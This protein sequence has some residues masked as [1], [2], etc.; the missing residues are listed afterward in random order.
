MG[1]LEKQQSTSPKQHKAFI[2]LYDLNFWS[3]TLTF[4]MDITCVIGNNF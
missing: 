2:D 3:P 1:D 4:R